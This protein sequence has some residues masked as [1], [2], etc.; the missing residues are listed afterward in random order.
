MVLLCGLLVA[1]AQGSGPDLLVEG[2]E[3]VQKVSDSLSLVTLSNGGSA[4]VELISTGS[5]AVRFSDGRMERW[6]LNGDTWS[7]SDSRGGFR[8]VSARSFTAMRD[9][10]TD[11]N[12]ARWS[13]TRDGY[14]RTI[15]P[16][17]R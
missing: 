15:R 3:R 1:Q 7:V 10:Y 13:Q 4:R 9:G 11:L 2:A 5:Y 14:T 16:D 8:T 12:G 6:T 17:G